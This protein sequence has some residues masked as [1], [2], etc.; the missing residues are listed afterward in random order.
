MFGKTY[1]PNMEQ[2]Q[3]HLSCAYLFLLQVSSCGFPDP[4]PMC[5]GAVPGGGSYTNNVPENSTQFWH[6]LDFPVAQTV[7]NPPERQETR[8]QSLGW[9]VPLE[10]GMAIHCSILAWRIPWTEKPGG[11]QSMRL[12]RVAHDW[13]TNTF[14]S[15]SE[16]EIFIL[17]FL[18]EY[19]RILE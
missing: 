8:V 1:F 15:F 7:K 11:L 6:C 2:T 10:K 16:I 14:L 12:Q 19:P 3:W 18:M 9:E 17:K 5:A 4:I 13:V